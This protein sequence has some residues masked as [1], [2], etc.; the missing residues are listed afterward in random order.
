MTRAQSRLNSRYAANPYQAT[1]DAVIGHALQ[2]Y[3][4]SRITPIHAAVRDHGMFATARQAC[5][6]DIDL[7]DLYCGYFGCMVPELTGNIERK[8]MAVY[9]VMPKGS[10]K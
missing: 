10:W 7:I 8:F 3:H 9:G 4:A 1:Q 2:K 6:L 5:K